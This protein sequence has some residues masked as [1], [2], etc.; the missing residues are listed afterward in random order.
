MISFARASLLPPLIFLLGCTTIP[1]EEATDALIG[2]WHRQDFGSGPYTYS[3][4]AYLADGRQ[5]VATFTFAEQF[6][7]VHGLLSQWSQT[8]QAIT[9][10]FGV[11]TLGRD[12]GDRIANEIRT[13]SGD[14]LDLWRTQPASEILERHR[15]LPDVK[16]ER[17]CELALHVINI[18]NAMEEM[19]EDRSASP[20]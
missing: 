12:I 18:Y 16:P 3:H 17:I 10:T 4:T 8:D 15:R 1:H 14:R 2:V 5:C 20:G 13:L 19:A 9:T 7:Q 6:T 11:N